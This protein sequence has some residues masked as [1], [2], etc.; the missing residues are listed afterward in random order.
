MLLR[1]LTSPIGWIGVAAI[2]GLMIG[3]AGGMIVGAVV[4]IG[5]TMVVGVVVRAAS[6]G[7]LPRSVRRSVVTNMLAADP[8]TATAAFP[9]LS[10][11][12]LFGALEKEVERIVRRAIAISPSMEVT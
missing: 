10:G 5:A 4:G 7:S 6:G 3:S 8:S 1:I 9:A 2:V 12:A 11:D